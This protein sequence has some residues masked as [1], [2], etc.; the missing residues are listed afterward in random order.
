MWSSPKRTIPGIMMKA[1]DRFEPAVEWYR[2]QVL[3]TTPEI[4]EWV[5]DMVGQV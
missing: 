4:M 2:P 1:D 3:S 5:G